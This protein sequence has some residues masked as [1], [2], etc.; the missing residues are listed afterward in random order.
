M[1]SLMDD[2]IVAPFHPDWVFA[3]EPQSLQYEK[4]SPYPTVTL[5]STR[6]VDKAGEEA[7]KQIGTQ[8]EKTLLSKSPVL[9]VDPQSIHAQIGFVQRRQPS[10]KARRLAIAGWRSER[11]GL[12]PRPLKVPDLM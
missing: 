1:G 3:G 9:L 4:R 12:R 5:V 10:E 8:N 2:G 7:T 11:R 6:V